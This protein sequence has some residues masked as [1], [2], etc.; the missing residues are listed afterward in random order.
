MKK[1]YK[2]QGMHCS[3]CAKMIEMEF[4]DRVNK[5]SASYE[6]GTVEIDFDEKKIA[7]KEIV[8]IIGK[9]GYKVI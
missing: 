1:T 9:L 7:E 2:I 3:S 5:I 4:E 8:Q 6:K